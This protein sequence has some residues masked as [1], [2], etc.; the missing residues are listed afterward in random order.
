MSE[1]IALDP[2]RLVLAALAGL[3]LL[4]VLIIKFKI[5][6]MISIFNRCHNNWYYSRY[7]VYGNCYG[8]K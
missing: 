7:A 4:L 1:A 8:G 2:A 5:H 6:A 3:A